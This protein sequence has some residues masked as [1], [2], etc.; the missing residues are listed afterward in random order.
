MN[1]NPKTSRSTILLATLAW[2]GAGII[3]GATAAD[4]DKLTENC[5]NCHGENGVSTESTVPT[6]AGM[7]ELFIIDTMAIYKDRDRPCVEAEYLAGP[8]KGSKTD[9][10]KI[11]DELGDDDIEALAKFYSGKEFVRAK[12]DFDAAKAELGA[13]IHDRACEKC[14]EDGGSVAEDD[15]GLLAGQWTPYLRQVFEAYDAGKRSMPKKMKP[16]WEDL[17]AEDKENLLHY[18][19]SLQ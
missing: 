2:L 11:A 5:T 9:M 19:G 12:Q 1:I 10:C 15:A 7:S 18:Y 8:D 3:N 14:N 13:K 16:K 6:I 17:S 4:L